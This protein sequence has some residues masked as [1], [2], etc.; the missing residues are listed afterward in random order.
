MGTQTITFNGTNA[1]TAAMGPADG[2]A[3][4]QAADVVPG[5]QAAGDTAWNA[6]LR[7]QPLA[8]LAALRAIT[9]PADGLTRYVLG[10]G[11]YTFKTTHGLLVTVEP[12][13]VA[14]T[15]ATPGRWVHESAKG[16]APGYRTVPLTEPYGIS[17]VMAWSAANQVLED[18]LAATVTRNASS[19]SF[20]AAYT[21]ASQARQL[22][23]SL[24]KYLVTGTRL[25][26][27]QLAIYPNVHGTLPTLP[28]RF[29]IARFPTD[30]WDPALTNLLAAGY[31]ED[32]SHASPATYD[33]VHKFGGSLD[34]NHDIDLAEYSYV[35]IVANE[36]GTNAQ[37]GL[38]LGACELVIS[39]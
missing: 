22:Y 38:A 32:A 24:D 14:A 19:T 4:I 37:N 27:A 8:T 23:F 10:Y 6:L 5:I 31:F 17:N 28:P 35:L 2:D 33:V 18:A 30:T 20:V 3:P 12:W 25:A 11:L 29:T 26:S 9:T 15:D 34:Q 13:A 39:P 7:V 21:A 1:P 36:G 16:R